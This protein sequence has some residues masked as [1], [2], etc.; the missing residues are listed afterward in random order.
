MYSKKKIGRERGER[1]EAI[2]AISFSFKLGELAMS[3]INCWLYPLEGV[4]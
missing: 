2:D 1:R 4:A 3:Y